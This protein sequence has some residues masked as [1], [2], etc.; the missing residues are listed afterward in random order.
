M[1]HTTQLPRAMLHAIGWKHCVIVACN[2]AEVEDASTLISNTA[3]SV[4]PCG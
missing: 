2:V 1:G 3:R 4:T